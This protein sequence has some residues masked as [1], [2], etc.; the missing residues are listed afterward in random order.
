MNFLIACL[1]LGLVVF[2]ITSITREIRLY[3]RAVKGETHYLVS[4]SRLRRRSVISALLLVEAGLLYFG[5]FH[6]KPEPAYR[7]LLYWFSAMAVM[8][9]VIL[10]AF[11]DLKETRR[12][13]DR[14]FKEA[15]LSAMKNVREAKRQ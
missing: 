5:N 3:R 9:V 13:V 4:R 10:L 8:I 1:S 12:D 15:V 6:L 11:K 14:I 7:A 2:S